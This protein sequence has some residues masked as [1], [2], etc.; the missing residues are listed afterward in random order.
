M[1]HCK[2]II[3]KTLLCLTL[4]L[5]LSGTS[6]AQGKLYTRKARLEDFP[7]RTVKV[8]TSG[9]SILE[10]TFREEITSR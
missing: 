5:G 1:N 2:E 6:F 10:S 8:V 3:I 9:S 7:A 4:L